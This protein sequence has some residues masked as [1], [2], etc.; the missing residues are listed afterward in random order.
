MDF[1]TDGYET[2]EEARL[3]GAVRAPYLKWFAPKKE[4]AAPPGEKQLN[5]PANGCI[6]NRRSGAGCRLL[7]SAASSKLRRLPSASVC[8][9]YR[10][11]P[12]LA[13]VCIGRG[14]L[15]MVE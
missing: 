8:T 1:F 13:L 2:A 5:H 12:V 7:L 11:G 3:P 9:G 6:S 15:A 4:P 14:F 10:D